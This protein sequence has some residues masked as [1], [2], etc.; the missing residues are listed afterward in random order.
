MHLLSR[1]WLPVKK[2]QQNVLIRKQL[3]SFYLRKM[4]TE[5]VLGIGLQVKKDTGGSRHGR[6]HPGMW[7]EGLRA[8]GCWM[9]YHMRLI[10][11]TVC[12]LEY[13]AR[14]STCFFQL[15][16]MHPTFAKLRLSSRTLS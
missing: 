13:T 14:I 15:L 5:L 10:R 7:M 6:P 12:E 11:S 16:S 9:W 8:L 1:A 3:V 4:H 2:L